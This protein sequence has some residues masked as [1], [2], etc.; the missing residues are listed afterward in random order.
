MLRGAQAISGGFGDCRGSGCASGGWSTIFESRKRDTYCDRGWRGRSSEYLEA[1]VVVL[2]ELLC[3]N[4]P[5]GGDQNRRDRLANNFSGKRS[6]API[7][8]VR[9]VDWLHRRTSCLLCYRPCCLCNDCLVGEGMAMYTLY[10]SVPG[11]PP[12][13]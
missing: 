7:W 13:Q 2:S 1:E 9:G 4:A 12:C 3:A 6:L 11:G 5:T 10:V 8:V